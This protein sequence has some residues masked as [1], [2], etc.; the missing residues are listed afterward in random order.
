MASGIGTATL[1]FGTGSNEASVAVTGQATISATSKVDAF[2]MADDSTGS[3]TA[4]DHRY[5]AC[6]VG[7]TCGT[8]SLTSGGSFTI[9]ATSFQKLQGTY[10][11]RW[12][13]A[14]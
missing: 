12:A 9:Y 11:V 14:D 13:W 2:V 4:A 7:L 8:P 5:F 1:D 6:L 10:T 3:H